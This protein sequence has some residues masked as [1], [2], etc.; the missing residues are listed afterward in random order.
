MTGLEIY[1]NTI[2]GGPWGEQSAYV[3]SRAVEARLRNNLF[4]A[5][6][7]ALPL[8][9]EDPSDRVRFEHNLYWRE[10]GPTEIAWGDRG[11][12]ACS[13]G[14]RAPGRKRWMANP[15]DAL[16]PRPWISVDSTPRTAVARGVPPLVWFRP[17]P[18]SPALADGLDLRR[19]FGV[20][21]VERDLLGVPLA[22]RFPLGAIAA[23]ALD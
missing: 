23:P 4:V 13:R 19:R 20:G 15:R 17:L 5:T 3:A 9:V 16:P 8:R 10:G 18:R 14:G 1:N 22:D 21:T 2:L 12:G 7:P 6:G 11:S